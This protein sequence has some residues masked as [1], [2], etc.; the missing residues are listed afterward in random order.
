MAQFLRP[1]SNTAVTTANVTGGFEDINE[2]VRSD[3]DYSYGQNNSNEILEVLLSAGTDPGVNTGHIVRWAQAQADDNAGTIAPSSG[4]TPS[5]IDVLLYQGATLIATCLATTNTNEGSFLG[6]SY[7][8]SAAEADAIT[9]YSDLRLHFDLNGSGGNPANRRTAAISWAEMEIPDFTGNN[10]NETINDA[11]SFS[12]NITGKRISISL[13]DSVVLSDDN[14]NSLNGATQVSAQISETGNDAE[15]DLADNSVSTTSSD[16]ELAYDNNQ[17]EHQLIGV[18]FTGLNIPSGVTISSAKIQ[19]SSDV[20]GGSGAVDLTIEAEKGSDPAIFADTA[21]NLSLRTKTTASQTWSPPDWTTLTRGADQLTSDFSSVLQEVI[22]DPA[23]S[24]GHAVVVFI[25]GNGVNT[26]FRR[27]T[28]FGSGTGLDPAEIIISYSVGGGLEETY[29]DTVSF[30]ESISVDYKKTVAD[31]VVV[32]DDTSKNSGISL[33]DSGLFNDA[34]NTIKGVALSLDDT[35]TLSEDASIKASLSIADII[36][37]S[38]DVILKIQKSLAEGVVLSDSEVKALTSSVSDLASFVDSDQKDASKLIG[39]AVSNIDSIVASARKTASD[40][41]TISDVYSDDSANGTNHV[42]NLDDSVSFQESASVSMTI[43]A[44][45]IVSFSESS[46]IGT[47]ISMSDT[48]SLSDNRASQTGVLYADGVLFSDAPF[49]ASTI[50]I[51]DL[52]TLLDQYSD[53]SADGENYVLGLSDAVSFSEDMQKK[54]SRVLSD[55]LLFSDN[56]DFVVRAIFQDA[57]V[58]VEALSNDAGAVREEVINF[59]S[60][61]VRTIVLDSEIVRSVASDSQIVRV[62]QI[63]SIL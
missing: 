60:I 9:D 59:D 18:R 4:G 41:V 24:Q 8:L 3:A 40:S 26:N 10:F 37:M 31:S 29:A 28:A 48:T 62:I 7:T 55:S 53:D 51:S 16:L 21:S 45:E 34:I 54:V 47:S 63:E 39:D 12:E 17:T 52:V 56:T 5:Q 38:E 2:A 57:T 61:I 13:G 36:S 44:D 1:I 50:P 30:S 19:F 25:S 23:Y 27:A 35:V 14:S 33:S 43:T 46:T 49:K 22:D 6:G 32:S 15:E 58:F 20:N 42:L 11:A